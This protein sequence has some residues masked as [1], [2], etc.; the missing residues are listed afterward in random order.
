[1]TGKERLRVLAEHLKTVPARDFSM[2]QWWCGTVGCAVGHAA[3]CPA[4]EAEGLTLVPC[5][6]DTRQGIPE[7]N[8]L[9]N[10]PAVRAFFDLSVSD[11]E[12]LF[13]PECY[14]D[15]DSDDDITLDDV[16]GRIEDY[17]ERH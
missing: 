14:Y 15:G 3:S 4:L 2:R 10:W 6:W 13:S 12:N 9:E 7:W 11:A 8:G 1:M 17:L 5:K 16:I